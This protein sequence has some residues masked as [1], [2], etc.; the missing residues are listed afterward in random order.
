M[1]LRAAHRRAARSTARLGEAYE[2]QQVL[3]SDYPSFG[4]EPLT[5][6]KSVG[7]RMLTFLRGCDEVSYL[8]ER[9]NG[10]VSDGH[11]RR[12]LGK[13]R[14][15]TS[16]VTVEMVLLAVLVCAQVHKSFRRTDLLRTLIGLHEDVARKVGL[17]DGDGILF[18][19]SYKAFAHQVLR[20]EE[21][22]RE[23]W[24][25]QTG[26]FATVHCDLRWFVQT[27]IKASIP[28]KMRRMIRHVAVDGTAVYSWGTWRRG[29]TQQDI[30]T[31]PVAVA[32][33]MSVEEN[34]DKIPEPDLEE[35]W[36]EHRASGREVPFGRDGRPRYGHDLDATIGYKSGN[37]DGD[38]GLFMGF[39]LHLAVAAPTVL[40]SIGR[41]HSAELAHVPAFVV[42]MSLDPAGTDCGP[43]SARIVLEAREACPKIDSATADRGVTTK[44]E[45]FLRTLHQNGV[46]VHMDYKEYLKTGPK[47]GTL[48]KREEEVTIHVGTFLSEHMP[49]AL[50]VPPSRLLKEG[51][52]EKLAK[53]YEDR[54][55][56]WGL[57]SKRTYSDGRRQF[58][59]P[60][61]AGRV[62]T[63]P[64]TAASPRGHS[65]PYIGPHN[66][67]ATVTAQVDELDLWQPHP[68]GTRAWHDVYHTARNAVE[69][70]NGMLKGKAALKRGTC[71]AF[72]IAANSLYALALIVCHNLRLA[73]KWAT[74]QRKAAAV[75]ALSNGSSSNGSSPNG[76]QPHGI[77]SSN[78]QGSTPS[79]APP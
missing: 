5:S 71:Q 37:D 51:Q 79:Q 73:A 66:A 46:D 15:Q 32:Q 16:A 56:L 75:A 69:R 60:A 31:E 67:R 65:V 70:V 43:I 52:E 4:E 42:G 9:L 12:L 10:E 41:L 78:G 61:A 21:V 28:R 76:S 47:G 54:A 38:A 26:W 23:G 53:W 77:T 17:I 18:V 34:T 48:G 29:V 62:A 57:S 30:D 3:P 49:D 39:D 40:S 64:A 20:L 19:P 63:S 7:M 33:K 74:G 24:A 22:L 25:V 58:R 59:L 13:R 1:K 8:Q 11:E 68:W 45:S 6:P 55:Q 27:L 2:A 35:L 50:W 44:R 72:G 14:G 36:N